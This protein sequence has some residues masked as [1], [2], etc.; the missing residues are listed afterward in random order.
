[1]RLAQM[2]EDVV[3]RRKLLQAL[4]EEMADVKTGEIIKPATKTE[5]GET[6]SVEF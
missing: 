6:I 2:E 4:T 3:S 1:M 5:G